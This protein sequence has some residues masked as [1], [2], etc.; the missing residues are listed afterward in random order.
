M[1]AFSLP[2]RVLLAGEESPTADDLRDQLQRQGFEVVRAASASEA[3]PMLA[4]L[5]LDAMLLELATTDA[6]APELVTEILRIEPK[7]V[8]LLLSEGND[9][10]TAVLCLQAGAADYL[11]GPSDPGTIIR[12]LQA[13]RERREAR[14]AE[15]LAA[16]AVREEMAHMAASL[17]R[18]QERVSHLAMATLD[19]LVCVV[20]A[21]DA[22]LAG[23]SVR[24][25]ELAACLA[26]EQGRTDAEIDAVRI[27]GRVH[28]I[29]MISVGDG[30]LSKEGPLTSEEFDQVKRHVVIGSQILSPLPQFGL[31]GSFVRSHHERWD[32]RGYPD[33]LAG[34]TIPWGARLLA[35]AEVYDALTTSRPYQETLTPEEAVR[36]MEQL[37]DTVISP[38]VYRALHTVVERRRA[39]VFVH[40]SA[41][42]MAR[43][44]SEFREADLASEF[45]GPANSAGPPA[46]LSP[47]NGRPAFS[48]GDAA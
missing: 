3:L 13:A 12:A 24:V 21:R 5:K 32:G 31:I 44:G 15:H 29:G 25:A 48:S 17:K 22:W 16:R 43:S 28:D 42:R 33:G 38:A 37:I 2:T 4:R 19:A 26:A 14:T 1:Y 40:D 47:R 23:H 30:I 46:I 9:A 6:F 41:P 39:L 45:P 20:E 11:T 34:E 8:L 7:L 10:R 18:E 35:A 36:Q 27:A